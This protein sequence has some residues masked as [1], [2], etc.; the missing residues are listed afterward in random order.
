MTTKNTTERTM[1]EQPKIEL[2]GQTLPV[3][4][5]TT[6]GNVATTYARALEWLRDKRPS[7]AWLVVDSTV[8]GRGPYRAYLPERRPSLPDISA[9]EA[10][11][12]GWRKIIE[13]IYATGI[14]D[15]DPE[16]PHVSAAAAIAVRLP[17]TLVE[18]SAYQDDDEDWDIESAVRWAAHDV[19]RAEAAQ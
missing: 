8:A 6:Q 13:K 10:W 7:C 14:Y 11:L 18:C 1:T 12:D 5:E 16:M 3:R 4:L 15:G 2:M 19:W 9:D 17:I